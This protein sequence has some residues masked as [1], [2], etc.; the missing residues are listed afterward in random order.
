MKAQNSRKFGRSPIL[1]LVAILGL[2][3]VCA[4]TAMGVRY[5]SDGTDDSVE[6]DPLD[7]NDYGSGGGGL[8]G[9]DVQDNNKAN[10]SGGGIIIA[11]PARE[12][13]VYLIVDF[14]GTIPVLQV[15]RIPG[16]VLLAEDRDAR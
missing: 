12:S 11:G 6:G 2:G 16:A 15:V 3:F 14:R 10:I 9:G 1:A 5:L 8:I 13:R 4:P 7:A